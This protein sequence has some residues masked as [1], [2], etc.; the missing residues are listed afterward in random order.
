LICSISAGLALAIASWLT[1]T[2]TDR[3]LIL[4]GAT[5]DT[6]TSRPSS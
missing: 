5:L 4:P 6:A 2:A 1:A 3:R